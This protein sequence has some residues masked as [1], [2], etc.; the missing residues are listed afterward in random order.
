M[1]QVAQTS[2]FEVCGFFHERTADLKGA[3]PRYPLCGT[4]VEGRTALR[5]GDSKKPDSSL[6]ALL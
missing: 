1:E 4:Y 5:L 3:G 6:P 2:V